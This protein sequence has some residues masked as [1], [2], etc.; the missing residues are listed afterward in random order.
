M[1][2]SVRKRWGKRN[3]KRLEN[4]VTCRT[5]AITPSVFRDAGCGLDL[6]LTRVFE[7]L[8][9]SISDSSDAAFSAP[10]AHL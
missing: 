6:K 7:A 10:S 9:L 4:C 3:S 5:E 8:P 1:S 2:V